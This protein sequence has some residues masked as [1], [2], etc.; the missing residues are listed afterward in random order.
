M[1]TAPRILLVE[2]DPEQALLFGQVLQMS[3]YQVVTVDTAEEAQASLAASPFDLLLADWA[4]PEMQGDSLITLAKTQYPAMKTI[5]YS[6]HSDVDKAAA[7]VGA[8]AWFR[9]IEGVT[10]L[11]QT[12][13]KLL[14]HD[15]NHA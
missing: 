14:P 12:I 6:N 11:R 7:V 3:G 9:K 5:L 10:L 8:D 15:A 13:S 4:L 1:T 2:D